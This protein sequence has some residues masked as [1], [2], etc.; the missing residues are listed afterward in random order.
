M[1]LV[2]CPYPLA[3]PLQCFMCLALSSFLGLRTLSKTMKAHCNEHILRAG[4]NQYLM[5]IDIYQVSL[6]PWVEYL[7]S[8]CCMLFSDVPMGLHT[9]TRHDSYFISCLPLSVSLLHSPPNV[10]TP[11]PTKKWLVLKK[12]Q[13]LSLRSH[14]L[15]VPSSSRHILILR[16][17]RLSWLYYLL[18]PSAYQYRKPT[19]NS[20]ILNIILGLH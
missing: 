8:M 14:I 13:L 12:C 7:W 15:F 11:L 19:R 17:N 4:H 6:S 5:G 3:V 20:N 9:F 18:F 2:P 16:L 10:S 1:L